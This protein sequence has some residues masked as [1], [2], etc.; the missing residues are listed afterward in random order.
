MYVITYN[1][2]YFTL[3]GKNFKFILLD[4]TLSHYKNPESNRIDSG[5]LPILLAIINIKF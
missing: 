1:S 3:F 5:F 4:I 2:N